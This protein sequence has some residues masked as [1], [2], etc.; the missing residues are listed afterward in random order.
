MHRWTSTRAVEAL[1]LPDHARAHAAHAEGAVGAPGDDAGHGH[2]LELECTLR[3]LR[4][5]PATLGVLVPRAEVRR[6]LEGHSR[7][8]SLSWTGARA[9][10][11]HR[12]RSAGRSVQSLGVSR[13]IPN[14]RA[15]AKQPQDA[16][17]GG[18]N[19]P[20]AAEP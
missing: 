15:F 12:V 4:S 19:H 1:G 8:A 14:P 18:M 10:V 9:E 5:A 11:L 13:R 17:S 2:A 20:V 7:G 6:A 16:A 3:E